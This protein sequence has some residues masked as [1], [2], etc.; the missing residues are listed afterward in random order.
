[1]IDQDGKGFSDLDL[2]FHMAI[3]AG[4]KNEIL[5]ELLEHIREGLQELIDNSLLLPAGRELAYKQHRALLEI[6]KQR[7]QR[8]ARTSVRTHLRSF[9]RGYKVLFQAPK[10]S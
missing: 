1:L 3:A 7:D 8:R 2:R 5:I 9:Q 10:E 6:L 4:S